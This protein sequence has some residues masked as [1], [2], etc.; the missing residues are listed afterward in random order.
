[1]LKLL[2]QIQNKILA[3][4]VQ[5]EKLAT[6]LD[7]E[8]AAIHKH[9]LQQLEGI[10]KE[11]EAIAGQSQ[12]IYEEL[13]SDLRA[14]GKELAQNDAEPVP[15]DTL[16]D[17]I[18][19]LDQLPINPVYA[20]EQKTLISNTQDLLELFS[21]TKYLVDKNYFILQKLLKSYQNNMKFWQ[22]LNDTTL[23]S[24]DEKGLKEKKGSKNYFHVRT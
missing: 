22:E 21:H 8:Y 11:K 2:K 24:Y 10:T 23:T 19:Q 4:K 18:T 5:Y 12:S 14:L 3:L 17:L 15:I 6:V 9:S 20:N 16:T 7:A 13:K 1:M